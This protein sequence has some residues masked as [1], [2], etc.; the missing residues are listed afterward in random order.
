VGPVEILLVIIL[1]I[2]FGA[3]PAWPY[4]Q[5]WGYYPSGLL[6]L[7][8]VVL[9]LFYVFPARADPIQGDRWRCARLIVARYDFFDRKGLCFHRPAIQ[10][11]W[12]ENR[13]SCRIRDAKDLT[14]TDQDKT[15]LAK[16]LQEERELHCSTTMR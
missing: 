10:K 8:M 16:S 12:P 5:S 15:W 11:A 2:A 1:L 9:L 4:S 3:L 14:L 7:L 13:G 6:L